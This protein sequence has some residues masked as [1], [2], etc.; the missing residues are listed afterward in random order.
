MPTVSI[1]IPC[2]NNAQWV[3]QAIESALRQ[4]HAQKE[5]I[6]LDDGSTDSSF[7]VIRSFGDSIHY[8]RI[9]NGGGNA[10]RNRLA[11]M[12][13]GEWLQF[14]DADDCL[15]P[16][17][18][19]GQLSLVSENI[20]AVYGSVTIQWWREGK[21]DHTEVSAP[22]PGRD[23]YGHW[24]D[25]QLAQTGAV[26]WRAAALRAIGGW[27][28][29]YPCCQDNEICF[30]ALRKGLAFRQSTD[31]GAVYR[32]WSLDTVSRKDPTRLI[33][34][35]ADLIG[36]MIEWLREGGKLTPEHT[37]CAAKALFQMAR[38]LAAHDLEHADRF[39]HDW[40]RKG[41]FK[42]D[43]GYAPARYRFL[44]NWFGFK[45]AEKAATFRRKR[46]I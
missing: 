34:T 28:E 24:L 4:T 12:A 22:D 21:V 11:A 6:V 41:L 9:P 8:E 37:D 38:G 36:Q 17:K 23:I 45:A 19:E 27:N 5:V 3:R 35:K 39:V 7:D 1:L 31:A 10:A 46:S 30:R 32:L 25:W 33:T 26:L 43:R 44:Y 40:K 14:L 18:V 16:E 42:C 20:D 2:H 29:A 15:L 13:S